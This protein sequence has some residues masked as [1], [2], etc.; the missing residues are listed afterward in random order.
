[1]TGLGD[2]FSIG[3]EHRQIRGSVGAFEA[4]RGYD[5]NDQF[6]ALWRQQSAVHRGLTAKPNAHVTANRDCVRI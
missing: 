6:P 1:M 3:P 2:I 5:A 4:Y